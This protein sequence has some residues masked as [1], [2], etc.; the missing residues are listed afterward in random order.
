MKDG[1]KEGLTVGKSGFGE[2]WA[3]D[4]DTAEGH[5]A[6]KID[7]LIASKRDTT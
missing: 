5:S 6:S 2:L 1:K 3:T 4:D 7:K